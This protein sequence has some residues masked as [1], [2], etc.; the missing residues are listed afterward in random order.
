MLTM[1]EEALRHHKMKIV[2]CA[3]HRDVEQ[4]ALLLELSGSAGA[5][6]RRHATVDHVEDIDRLP[7]LALRRMD[8]RQDEVVLIQEKHAGLIQFAGRE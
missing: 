8:R 3:R 2:L 4:A 6:V 7:F 1:C 5:E